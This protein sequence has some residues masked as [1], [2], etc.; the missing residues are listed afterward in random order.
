MTAHALR[1]LCDPLGLDPA[2]ATRLECD[3]M[4]RALSFVLWRA[5]IEH[6][7]VGGTVLFG[8]RCLAHYWLEAP[9]KSGGCWTI[10]YRLGMWFDRYSPWPMPCGVFNRER[11]DELCYL[12]SASRPPLKS[13]VVF[14]ILTCHRVPVA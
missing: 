13:A 12:P 3:G 14:D 1:K 9:R 8:T 10:D 6:S 7:M 4:S 5:G 2:L 11:Y